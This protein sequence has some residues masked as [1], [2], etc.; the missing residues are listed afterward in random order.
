ML[1]I[2][3][4]ASCKAP[5]SERMTP[6]LFQKIVQLPPDTITLPEP[7]SKLPFWPLSVVSNVI[8]TAYKAGALFLTREAETR[9]R[10][11]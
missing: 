4:L 9:P 7:L 3:L 10:V 6:E 2:G 1:S 5:E 11:R 8:T